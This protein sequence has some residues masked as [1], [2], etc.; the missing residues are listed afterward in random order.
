MDKLSDPLWLQISASVAPV[1]VNK[2]I[3]SKYVFE[4]E[5]RRTVITQINNIAL[6]KNAAVPWT[7]F[8]SF[9]AVNSTPWVVFSPIIAANGSENANKDRLMMIS[10]VY[11]QNP[12]VKIKYAIGK[13]IVPYVI[14]LCEWIP[15]K[16]LLLKA[17]IFRM[18]KIK[19]RVDGWWYVEN[20]SG[21]SVISNPMVICT[22][23]RIEL[24]E[25]HP[26]CRINSLPKTKINIDIS[27]TQNVHHSFSNGIH[28]GNCM[29]KIILG[30]Y[31]WQRLN[32]VNKRS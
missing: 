20:I 15:L 25:S 17:K 6:I 24:G 27:R 12:I 10:S 22:N 19:A 30:V 11:C 31:K 14:L 26:N 2:V 9:Q 21:D 8:L 23:L 18:I 29:L 28:K 5:N 32:N 3:K 7:V 1:A 16:I 13:Y 4:Y